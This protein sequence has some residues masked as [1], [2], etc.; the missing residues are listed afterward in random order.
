MA[1]T[2]LFSEA[3]K[4][5][6]LVVDD[7]ERI[8]NLISR[9][10]RE[11]GFV[12]ATAKDAA[13]AETVMTLALF[14]A[15][16]VDVMMPGKTGY[17]MTR[18]LR[19][20]SQIPILL[21]TALGEI[22]N[23][24]EGL[25]SG[26]DDYLSKPFEPKELLL[27]L[28]SILRRHRPIDRTVDKI[29]IGKWMYRINDDLVEGE[30]GEEVRLTAV[31]SRLLESLARQAGKILSR[32]ELARLCGVDGNDRTVDVQITRLRKKIEED[33]RYPRYIQTIRGQGYML[34]Q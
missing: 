18:D 8:R 7:D 21:L 24:I 32:D 10:L 30:D 1:E 26:A 5:H 14:D 31:E 15:L 17:E 34:K 12:V 27:R 9:Y 20:T 3:D 29:K 22:D 28:Q 2:M 11:N 23:R 19:A 13:D 16:I 25:E 6:I 33:S 4:P